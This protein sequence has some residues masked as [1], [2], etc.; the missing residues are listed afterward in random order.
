MLTE[1]EPES[2]ERKHGRF[3]TLIEDQACEGWAQLQLQLDQTNTDS[4]FW[5]DQSERKLD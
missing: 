4:I 5:I 3:Q 1:K 2:I